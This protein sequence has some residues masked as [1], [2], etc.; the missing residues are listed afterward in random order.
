MYLRATAMYTD[1]QGSGKD[2]SASTDNPVSTTATAPTLLQQYDTITIDGSIDKE[3]ARAAVTDYFNG[4]IT[5]EEARQ[6]LTLYFE[7]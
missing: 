5:K 4:D 1:A 2:A 6:V 3:E 7:S